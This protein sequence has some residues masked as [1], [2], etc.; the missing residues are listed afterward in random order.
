MTGNTR[1]TLLEEEAVLEGLDKGHSF[2]VIGQKIGR[3]AKAVASRKHVLSAKY[4]AAAKRKRRTAKKRAPKSG[5]QLPLDFG[6]PVH[7]ADPDNAHLIAE[8]TPQ[9]KKPW[10]AYSATFTAGV[11]FGALAI[12]AN[13]LF[14]N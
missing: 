6:H 12:T 7:V 14:F 5:A 4:E 2:E 11:V 3:T 8:P 1:W 10:A 9:S 13:N